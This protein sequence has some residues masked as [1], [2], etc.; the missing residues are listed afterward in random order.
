[1]KVAGL[2]KYLGQ[3]REVVD[4]QIGDILDKLSLYCCAG[5]KPL[6]QEQI[7]DAATSEI[8]CSRYIASRHCAGD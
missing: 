6:A 5:F 8:G 1:M 4:S 3:K 2:R 7:K